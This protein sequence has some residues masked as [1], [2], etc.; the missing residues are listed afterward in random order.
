MLGTQPS[1]PSGSGTAGEALAR[2]D[3]AQEIAS[4]MALG[5]M[6][7]SVDQI[8]AAI[9][10]HRLG[11][12]GFERLPVQK[13]EF[14]PSDHAADVEIEWELVLKRLAFHRRQ[15]FEIGEEIAHLLHLHALV[16]GVGEN[17]IVVPAAGRGSLPHGGDEVRF[18]PAADAVVAVR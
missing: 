5:A 4:T 14:P 12:V 3:G 7:C 1:P 6:A 15:R 18:A 8:S 2:D 16:G 10:L 13:Q 9:E 11:W 17:R